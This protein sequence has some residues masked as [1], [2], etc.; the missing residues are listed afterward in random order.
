MQQLCNALKGLAWTPW[1]K[2]PNAMQ[3]VPSEPGLYF[4]R[5]GQ[6]MTTD[7]CKMSL[8]PGLSAAVCSTPSGHGTLKELQ[9]KLSVY[10]RCNQ[11][12][13]SLLYIGK[14]GQGKKANRGLRWR[15]WEYYGSS[16]VFDQ[17]PSWSLCPRTPNFSHGG[18][19]AVWLLSGAFAN[20]EFTW[21]EY[22]RLHQVFPTV[23][24]QSV[25]PSEIAWAETE[26]L[27]R[28]TDCV[29]SSCRDG[30]SPEAAEVLPSQL[31]FPFGN[32]RR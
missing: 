2:F 9:A 30:R 26:L 3:K 18:G 12:A 17:F 16:I 25:R 14:A 6:Q 4:L 19:K 8:K 7:W 23:F 1:A 28:Y 32:R 5:W 10:C 29:L 15:I 13:C 11:P 22:S 24:S 21:V 20:A 31:R 27:Q